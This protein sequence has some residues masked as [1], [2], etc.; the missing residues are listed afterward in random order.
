[1]ATLPA[2]WHRPSDV[3]AALLVVGVWANVAGL[4]ILVAQGGHA[5]SPT[6][7]RTGWRWSPSP[8]SGSGCWPAPHSR[9]H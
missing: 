6:G 1:V 9:W 7:R 4:F 5:T 3:V 8:W 2:G